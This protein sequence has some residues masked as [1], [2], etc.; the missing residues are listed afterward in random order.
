MMYDDALPPPGEPLAS[1][2]DEGLAELLEMGSNEV[3]EVLKIP[4]SLGA[5]RPDQDKSTILSVRDRLLNRV[6][7]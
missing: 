3:A 7:L 5:P 2:S 1:V 4:M 6:R